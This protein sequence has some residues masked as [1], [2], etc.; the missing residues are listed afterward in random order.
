MF[1]IK[2]VVVKML[3]LDNKPEFSVVLDM[4]EGTALPETAN[5]AQQI[6]EQIR[7]VPEVTAVQIYAGTAKP[8]D[9][10]GMVRHYYLRQDPWQAE[11]QVQLLDKDNRDRSS[12]EI[13]VD[14]R[15]EMQDLIKDSDARIAVVEMPPGPPVLQSVVAEVHGPDRRHRQKVA[16]R[17]TKVFEQARSLVDVDNYMRSSPMNTGNSW[18]IGRSRTGAVFP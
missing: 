13:A 11:M 17:L 5:R 4:P 3:P 8:I 15:Q 7:K 9:F 10:N 2:W 18:W 12:H 1:Y 16:E 6:A 14:A